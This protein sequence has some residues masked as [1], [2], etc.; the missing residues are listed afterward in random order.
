MCA[1]SADFLNLRE[2]LV[3]AFLLDARLAHPALILA[4][5]D[6]RLHHFALLVVLV[7]RQVDWDGVPGHSPLLALLQ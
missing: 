3:P 2:G 4:E 6:E 1:S 7:N 5:V